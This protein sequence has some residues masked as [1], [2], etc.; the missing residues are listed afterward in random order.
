VGPVSGYA[1]EHPLEFLF[2]AEGHH[3]DR[4]LKD[5]EA[6][7]LEFFKGDDCAACTVAVYPCTTSHKGGGEEAEEAEPMAVAPPPMPEIAAFRARLA[8]IEKKVNTVLACE[9]MLRG[10]RAMKLGL[11]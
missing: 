7:R 1:A 9:E 3:K 10:L 6:D 8:E 2:L 11:M 5:M 4:S